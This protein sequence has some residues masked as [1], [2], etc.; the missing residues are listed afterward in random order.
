V[1][2]AAEQAPAPT[3]A[4][5]GIKVGWM[6]YRPAKK[7]GQVQTLTLLGASTEEGRLIQKGRAR[8]EGGKVVDDETASLLERS[9]QEAGFDRY[10]VKRSPKEPTAG[11]LQVVW[12]DRG[13][14]F[15]S[16][17]LVPGARQNPDTRGLP[18]VFDA[19]KKLIFSVHQA[20]PGSMVLTGEGW[21]GDT[22]TNQQPGNK[23]R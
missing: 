23:N 1:P 7:V 20:S 12:I 21:S 18:D 10:A 17:Y 16:L 4:V 2:A 19:L 9:F 3:R 11:A 13:N 14:G 6:D 22:L 15:E 8:M 5:K